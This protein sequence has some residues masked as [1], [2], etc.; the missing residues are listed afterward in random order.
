MVV[1]NIYQLKDYA[2]KWLQDNYNM[3]LEIPLRLNGR[4]QRTC[5]WFKHKGLKKQPIVVELN[6]FFVENNEPM[7]VLDILRHELV[8]YAMYMQGR[9]YKD[10]SYGFER[11]LKRL[12]VVSQSTI[13]K[14]EITSKPISAIVYKCI[15]PNCGQEY[16]RQRKLQGDGAFHKCHC[17]GTIRNMGKKLITT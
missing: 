6:K 1:Y 16:S 2:N 4:M 9:D 13:D 8:H 11:E 7:L 3:K 12:G 10:G 15:M 5:G 17:G 14:Y